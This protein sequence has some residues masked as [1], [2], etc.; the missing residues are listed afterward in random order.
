MS[1]PDNTKGEDWGSNSEINRPWKPWPN[2]HFFIFAGAGILSQPGKPKTPVDT[3]KEEEFALGATVR[4][5]VGSFDSNNGI[6][7]NKPL[8]RRQMVTEKLCINS[9]IR[10]PFESENPENGR[11]QHFP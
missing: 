3:Q 6:P 4:P 2:S 7:S 8:I 10:A 11:R 5:S 9:Q 1:S